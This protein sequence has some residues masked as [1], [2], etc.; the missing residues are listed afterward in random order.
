MVHEPRDIFLR[1]IAVMGED[2][3]GILQNSRAAVFGIG[4]VGTACAEA[5]VRAGIGHIALIDHDMVSPSNL[6]RQLIALHS[7]VDLPKVQAAKQRYLDINPGLQVETCSIF[8][9]EETSSQIHLPSYDA[10]IDCMDT[11]SAKLLL[12]GEAQQHGFYLLSCMG[13][14]NRMD[15][16]C[17]RFGD[18]Y[19]TSICPLARRMRKA[20]REAGIKK[21]RVLY[22]TEEPVQA[23]TDTSHGRN[24]PGS[25]SF[26]PPVG[27]MMLAGEAIRHLIDWKG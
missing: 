22:S 27:G 13:T 6:N 16:S 18:I 4:G 2:A 15:P 1:S 8:Y 26:M 19:E 5:L 24:A 10:V 21:L 25:V 11:L 3:F 12:A 7:T 17:L 14:G 9:G 23:I 20:C